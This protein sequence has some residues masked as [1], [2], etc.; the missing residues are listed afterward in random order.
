MEK[1]LV[2]T[3]PA[4]ALTFWGE[5]RRSALLPEGGGWGSV[6]GSEQVAACQVPGRNLWGMG[7]GRR[8]S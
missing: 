5:G 7:G 3:Y 1:N 6:C 4:S 8:C 2:I